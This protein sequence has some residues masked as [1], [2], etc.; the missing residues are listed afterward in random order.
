MDK[1]YRNVEECNTNK[2]Y[3]ISIIFD[4]INIHVLSNKKVNSLATELFI[5]CRKLNISLIFIT[6]FD[7]KVTKYVTLNTTHFLL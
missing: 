1:I 7:F 5:R 3:K 4:E 6:Q 2:K